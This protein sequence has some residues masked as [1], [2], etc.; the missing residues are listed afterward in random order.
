MCLVDGAAVGV[1]IAAVRAVRLI[2]LV[3]LLFNA[4]S[5]A[6]GVWRMFW[7]AHQIPEFPAPAQVPALP[8]GFWPMIWNVIGLLWVVAY[9]ALVFGQWR[10]ARLFAVLAFLPSVGFAVRDTLAESLVERGSAVPPT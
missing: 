4:V 5:A 9:L 7:L 8:F 1:Q 2:A 6:W 10:A 3:V